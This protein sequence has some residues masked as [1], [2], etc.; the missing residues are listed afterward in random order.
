MY[1]KSCRTL[2]IL[3]VKT[4]DEIYLS[5]VV[6]ILLHEWEAQERKKM[7]Y[8]ILDLDVVRGDNCKEL[9]L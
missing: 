2:I 7:I 1:R 4:K 6:L 8:S 5:K 3:L 9:Y